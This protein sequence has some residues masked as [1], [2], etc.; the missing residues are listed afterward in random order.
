MLFVVVAVL[1]LSDVVAETAVGKKKAEDKIPV[2]E[3]R[4]E[5]KPMSAA[6]IR[7]LEEISNG[8][9]LDIKIE[10][11]WRPAKCPR[12]A[13]R[14]DFVTFH[15]KGFLEDGKKYHQTYGSGPITIQLGTGMA[16]PGLDKGL[17]GMCDQ[18]LRKINVPFRLSRKAKSKVWK[19]IP[20]DEHWLSFNIEML[21]V[22][23]WN[24]E[25]QFKYLDMN[26]DGYITENDAIKFLDNQKRMYGKSWK[27]EDIDNVLAARYYVKYFDVDGDTKVSQEEFT[28]IMNRDIKEMESKAVALSND[29]NRPKGKRRDP[30][31]AW[32]LDF[33]NDGIVSYEENDSA[34]VVLQ[35]DPKRLPQK[36]HKEEL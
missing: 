19:Q 12:E 14:L 3:L 26:E 29:K 6:Q 27:N 34:D 28:E 20:N 2:I 36:G 23:E 31:V 17:R 30:G 1:F 5:G 15:Y 16:M 11:T 18:E 32:I 9:P 24:L 22:K 35:S 33:N 25:R 10:K 8:G 21:E 13:Q 7:Q 4:G